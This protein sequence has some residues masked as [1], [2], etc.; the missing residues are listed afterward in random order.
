M[1]TISIGNQTL[2]VSAGSHVRPLGG[3]RGAQ[4]LVFGN[5]TLRENGAVFDVGAGAHVTLGALQG[6]NYSLTKAGAGRLELIGAAPSGGRT[7]GGT[8]LNGGTLR[9]KNASALGPS[10]TVGALYLNSGILALMGAATTYFS[11][12]TELG[13]DATVE[14]GPAAIGA[15]TTHTLGTLSLDDGETLPSRSVGT[16][17]RLRA[18]PA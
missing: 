11:T 17:S 5:T 16:N 10:G 13:G 9:L 4:E 1:G 18:R 12:A 2:S 6:G 14:V 8:Y 7:A 3:E 15:G